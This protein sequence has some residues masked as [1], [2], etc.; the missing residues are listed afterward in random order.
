MN[1]HLATDQPLLNLPS[2]AKTLGLNEAVFPWD[3]PK[4]FKLNFSAREDEDNDD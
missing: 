4:T 2:L 1:M 3:I